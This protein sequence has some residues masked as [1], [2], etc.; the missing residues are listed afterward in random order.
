K[1]KMRCWLPRKRRRRKPKGIT[2]KERVIAE[3]RNAHARKK[4]AVNRRAYFI[5]EFPESPAKWGIILSL[6]YDYV[7][8]C[9]LEH[10]LARMLVYHFPGFEMPD[11]VTNWPERNTEHNEYDA[12]FKNH[13]EHPTHADWPK[14]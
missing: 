1:P 5:R 12:W 7:I 10:K 2:P 4:D 13:R 14:V 6:Q 9:D 8:A 3:L 11:Y